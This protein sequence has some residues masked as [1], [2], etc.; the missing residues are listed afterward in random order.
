MHTPHHTPSRLRHA[1]GMSLM[2]VLIVCA[3][4]AVLA[5]LLFPS[6]S[7]ATAAARTVKC[8]GNLRQLF[9]AVQGFRNDNNGLL[10]GSMSAGSLWP[11]RIAPYLGVT[12]SGTDIP[13]APPCPDTPFLCPAV[14]AD[15]EPRRSY[16]FNS[17]LQDNNLNT[18]DPAIGIAL[19]SQTV[20]IADARNTSWFQSQANASFRHDH[21]MANFLMAD[22][23]VEKMDSAAANAR[24]YDVFIRGLAN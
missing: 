22:G 23:H 5:A 19:P 17:R 10:P 24:P 15:S 2:E 16:A 6:L 9:I 3:I 14:Y 12:L 7:R 13:G 4:S 20:L 1:P 18:D 8:A 11:Q 21:K